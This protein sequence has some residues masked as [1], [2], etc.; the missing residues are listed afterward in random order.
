[1]DKLTKVP[2]TERLRWMDE[3]VIA[4]LCIAEA[5]LVWMIFDAI[6][7]IPSDSPG[8]VPM[9][10]WVSLLYGA[11]LAPRLLEELN[12]WNPWYESILT[13]CVVLSTLASIKVICFPD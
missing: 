12:I 9:G 4:A 8:A 5:A 7:A 6:F 10:G 11:A 3:A 1:M 2:T 13:C